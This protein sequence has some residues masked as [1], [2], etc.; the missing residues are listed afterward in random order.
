MSVGIGAR[1]CEELLEA[2]VIKMAEV[3]GAEVGARGASL[4]AGDLMLLENTRFHP[5]ETR[6]DPEFAKALASLGDIFVS[7]AFGAIHRANAST[8]GVAKHFEQR[9]A[10]FL[11][12]AEIAFVERILHD[13]NRPLVAILCGVTVSA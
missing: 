12:A 1:R 13:P 3:G 4:A 9:A 10:G 6:N 2:L 5:G 8:E 11:V 7:E